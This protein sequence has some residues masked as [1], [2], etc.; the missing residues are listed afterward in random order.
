[1]PNKQELLKF[2][3]RRVFNPILHANSGG[4][5]NSKL[6]D[7]QRRT[8]SEKERFHHYRSASEIITNYKRDLHS[9]AAKKVNRELEQLNLP[10]LP[11]VEDDFLK[12]AGEERA[13]GRKSGKG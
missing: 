8:E 6:E 2:L 9:S 1:M 11:S 10:T 3:D 7:V 5:N 12:L 4:H 13:H